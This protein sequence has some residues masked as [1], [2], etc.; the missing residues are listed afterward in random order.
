MVVSRSDKWARSWYMPF[1][2][3]LFV[4]YLAGEGIQDVP[5]PWTCR[6]RGNSV[7]VE[8]AVQSDLASFVCHSRVWCFRYLRQHFVNIFEQEPN[9]GAPLST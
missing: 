6:S 2:S 1:D 9:I 5:T 3:H 4:S 8:V 7:E